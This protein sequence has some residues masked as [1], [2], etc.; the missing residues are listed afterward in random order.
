MG[1]LSAI[2]SLT[3]NWVKGE[4]AF[5]DLLKFSEAAKDERIVPPMQCPAC[6]EMFVQTKRI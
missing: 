2:I 5:S 1:E 6:V 3:K 4:N